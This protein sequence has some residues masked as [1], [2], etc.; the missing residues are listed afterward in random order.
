MNKTIKL[1][2]LFAGIGAPRKA[3]TNLG[4][5][6]ESL[7]Y[8][9]IDTHAIKSYCAIHGDKEENNFG[10]IS[11]IDKLPKDISLLFHRS[12]CQDFSVAG[13]G[14]GGEKDSGTRSSLLW[15]TIRLVEE[16]KPNVVIWENVKGV[17]NK[18]NIEVFNDYLKVLG[19]MG[20]KNSY[21]V[22]NAKDFGI[23]Q[24]RERIFVVSSLDGFFDFENIKK[25]EMLPLEWFVYF[26]NH[27]KGKAKVNQATKQGH[28]GLD[29]PGI[30]NLERPTSDTRRGRVVDKGNVCPTIACSHGLSAI[31]KK[32]G[33]FNPTNSKTNKLGYFGEHDFM[34]K[35][36]YALEPPIKCLTVKDP[37]WYLDTTE[38]S[39]KM[40]RYI[41]QPRSNNKPKV[42]KINPNPC[43]TI[44]TREGN[45]RIGEG[46]YVSN[47]FEMNENV[48][49]ID[50]T[51]F[52]VRKLAPIEC[53]LLMGFS[54]EDFEK[55]SQVC[56][57]SQLYKQAGNSIVVDVLE[58][59]FK[60]LYKKKE[61][62]EKDMKKLTEMTMGEIQKELDRIGTL[63]KEIETL[64][65]EEPKNTGINMSKKDFNKVLTVIKKANEVNE[66]FKELGFIENDET[67]EET[68]EEIV[69]EVEK[70]EVEVVIEGSNNVT[71]IGSNNEVN[72]EESILDDDVLDVINQEVEVEEEIEVDTLDNFSQEIETDI[73]DIDAILNDLG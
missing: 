50:L 67:K 6:Y 37:P 63:E 61:I 19:D 9:E 52:Q 21:K 42:Q 15:E 41:T 25:K 57:N 20:Y 72:V 64:K 10:D 16:A 29:V 12:P 56:S 65:N 39:D 33:E 35:R 49:G 53:Y 69:E 1:F 62:K 31:E 22:L 48:L 8:S 46:T 45:T 18:K 70:E 3:L 27:E 17:L 44:T 66:M 28:I 2:E 4:I 23:P 11:K 59:I 73:Q 36:V 34:N 60:E 58:A 30:A 7:G 32:Y 71:N 38:L 51:Q 40:K 14:K 5:P 55:A 24:S 68:K 47:D 43:N 26:A 13:L 54:V